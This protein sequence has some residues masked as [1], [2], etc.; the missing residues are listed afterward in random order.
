MKRI[1]GLFGVLGAVVLAGVVSAGA[2]SGGTVVLPRAGQ[3]GIGV[4][5]DFGALANGGILGKEFGSGAGIGVRLRYRMRYERGIGLS[6]D[7]F[8]LDSRV[9]GYPQGAFSSELGPADS[10]LTRDQ[11]NLTTTGF[12]LF[13]FFGTRQRDV[14][15]LALGAG[16]A[17]ISATLSSGETQYPL[18]GDGTFLSASGGLEHFF[19]RS[20]AVDVSA[21]YQAIFLSSTVNHNVQASAGL[22]F[23]AA[24]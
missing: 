8:Q 24:Y 15:W 19:Y 5:G 11:L 10:S 14:K 1:A 6:F 3:V 9:L 13:Q 17:Q 7:H 20:W 22:V 12:E 18:G 21:R 16:L 23:Y 4:V 2:A